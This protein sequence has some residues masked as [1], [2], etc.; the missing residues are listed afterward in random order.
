MTD[1][2]SHT[3]RGFRLQTLYIVHNIL[4]SDQKYQFQPEGAEDLAVYDPIGNLI[5]A[6]QVKSGNPLQTS[7]LKSS[8]F[9]RSIERQQ[10]YPNSAL[11][12]VKFGSIGA[13]LKQAC[14]SN[15][16]ERANVIQKLES[17]ADLQKSNEDLKTLLDS[18]EAYEVDENEIKSE[19]EKLLSNTLVGIDLNAAFDLMSMWVYYA[20]ENREFINQTKLREKITNIGKYLSGRKS[21]HDQWFTTIEPLESTPNINTQ[22]ISEGYYQGEAARFSHILAGLDVVRI[23]K[24]QRIH[25]L[26]ADKNILFVHGVSG[27][28]K[29]TLVYR[30]LYDYFPDIWRFQVKSVDGRRDA[31]NSANALLSH[32]K[33]LN[34]PMIVFMDISADDKG[35]EEL[36]RSLSEDENIKIL[37]AIR[38][39][40][41]IQSRITGVEF[42]FNELELKF[43]QNEAEPIY[44]VLFNRNIVTSHLRFMDAWE[45][46]GGTG[47]LLEFVYLITQ[48][49]R[50]EER[51]SSQVKR[52]ID[53]SVPGDDTL[54]LLRAVAVATSSGSSLNVREIVSSFS[55]VH[56]KTFKRLESE[57]L[58]RLDDSQQWIT[59]VHPIRSKL[60]EKILI[61]DGY[62]PWVGEVKMVLPL[63]N[64]K[65]IG[66]FLL[67]AFLNHFE[68]CNELIDILNAY[69]P[70]TWEAIE[71]VA[72]ALIWYSVKEFV[73]Q[74]KE[75]IQEIY[76]TPMGNAVL[77]FSADLTH[78]G[79]DEWKKIIKTL[80]P[81]EE[82]QNSFIDIYEKLGVKHFRFNTLTH[83]FENHP[84]EIHAPE[85]NSEWAAF[86]YVVL[87]LWKCELS[88]AKNLCA[89]WGITTYNSSLTLQTI[90]EVTTSLFYAYPKIF[91][92]W[93][94]QYRTPSVNLLQS[95]EQI[96]RIELNDD[97]VKAHFITF[98]LRE[99]TELEASQDDNNPIHSKTMRIIDQLRLLFPDKTLYASQGYGH[100][101]FGIDFPDESIKNISQENF[102]LKEFVNVNAMYRRVI[103]NM[104][105]PVDWNEYIEQ[106]LETREEITQN[107]MTLTIQLNHYF[108]SKTAF[109]PIQ[110]SNSVS[111]TWKVFEEKLKSK[112]LLPKSIID[113]WGFSDEEK[114]SDLTDQTKTTTYSLVTAQ[115]TKAQ[116]Y[117]NSYTD[118]LGTFVFQANTALVVNGIIGKSSQDDQ[119]ELKQKFKDNGF[120]V[121]GM[122]LSW[123]HLT[124]SIS[125]LLLFQN[126]FRTIFEHIVDQQRLNY[127][128][129]KEKS[130]FE[131][132]IPI[133]YFFINHSNTI[134]TSKKAASKFYDDFEK[135]RVQLLD[136]F[137]N[138]LN[139][140]ELGSHYSVLN[141]TSS[142]GLS[143]SLWIKVSNTSAAYAWLGCFEAIQLSNK[144]IHSQTELSQTIMKWYW[145]EIRF[146]PEYKGYCVN[147]LSIPFQIEQAL[148]WNPNEEINP[149]RH[150]PIQLSD[151]DYKLIE[152]KQ[153]AST[154]IDK[155]QALQLSASKLMTSL[156][157]LKEFQKCPETDTEVE[158]E[159]IKKYFQE[160]NNNINNHLND[161]IMNTSDLIN[162]F[163]KFENIEQN[164][165]TE[166]IEALAEFSM[167]LYPDKN[168]G[169]TFSIKLEEG[170]VWAKNLQNSMHLI[171][172]RIIPIIM[173]FELAN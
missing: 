78:I 124:N 98:D 43:D 80:V 160:I 106:V 66:Q 118:D 130:A 85:T 77:L 5:E 135:R 29:S 92:S 167:V 137:T 1:N 22:Q 149:L 35:W 53:E 61:D 87:W 74:K 148:Y 111:N 11:K 6:V 17:R 71:G 4:T 65:H 49:G 14:L 164:S 170:E 36:I 172:S 21:Y 38:D 112:L 13:E 157:H 101:G 41:W 107:L 99:N 44:D 104:F 10:A 158:Q 159:I 46:F 140:N 64:Q 103:K 145:S 57:Y 16:K 68:Q 94:S 63:L 153:Y 113:P 37:I 123:D 95:L 173:E 62:A 93:V 143:P 142:Y 141:R 110:K 89:D 109:N 151:S 129:K 34:V 84:L 116:K 59:A 144:F 131:S 76:N 79:K 139:K 114:S 56:E 169:D 132:L 12:L 105:R 47:P 27:Q 20:S 18:T 69:R 23:E 67:H 50:L 73:E 86:A 166:L 82:Q 125:S 75:Y 156:L 171:T 26:L 119:I 88:E 122:N 19:I 40:D 54:K 83:W 126:E 52:L 3:F 58:L 155:I 30:Y 45:E 120:H 108:L 161:S 33:A 96:C 117:Y 150:I 100:M 55:I 121:D 115:Y 138:Y 97:T 136:N 90:G 163:K 128:E 168:E 39:E 81:A 154:L 147:G 162:A 127:L 102:P 70:E 31:L 152:L 8:F 28:G 165:Y 2:A 60:L 15:G 146:L 9:T 72:R 91:E 7:D 32:A 133:W 48:G 134:I 51:L 25:E 42:S 24:L